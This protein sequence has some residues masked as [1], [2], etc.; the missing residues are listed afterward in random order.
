[1]GIEDDIA[2]RVKDLSEATQAKEAAQLKELQ[3]ARRRIQEAMQGKQAPPEQPQPPDDNSTK[4]GESP[5]IGGAGHIETKP[6]QKEA[7]LDPGRIEARERPP[8]QLL[9]Q[10]GIRR[11]Q[12]RSIEG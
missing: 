7:E 11:M 10:E 12:G 8:S 2:K 3:E 5:T 6:E 1:V 9:G 4:P